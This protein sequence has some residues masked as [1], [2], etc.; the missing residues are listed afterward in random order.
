MGRVAQAFRKSTQFL[1]AR[2]KRPE[3]D[4][5]TPARI[6]AYRPG[7]EFLEDRTMLSV[8]SAHLDTVLAPRT[9]ALGDTTAIAVVNSVPLSSFAEFAHDHPAPS[10]VV[11]VDAG[12]AN[13]AELINGI[14]SSGLVSASSGSAMP[15]PQELSLPANL[16]STNPVLQVSFHGDTEVVVLDSGYDGIQQISAILQPYHGLSAEQVLSHG[17][18]GALQL[19]NTILDARTL[20]Q[21]QA[22]ISA[23]GTALQSGGDIFLYGCDVAQGAGGVQFVQS[24]AHATGA[25]VAANTKATG[26]TAAGGDWNLDY[27]TGPIE[28][29]PVFTAAADA[30]Y[31]GLLGFGTDLKT[32]IQDLLASES[33]TFSQTETISNVS[34]GGFLQLN[35]LTLTENA[36]LSTEGVWSGT[37]GLSATSATLFP[38]SSFSASITSTVD[39]QPALT[40]TFTIGSTSGPDFS[41]SV[42]S[43]ANLVINVGEALTI[44]ASNVSFNY[45]SSPSASDTQTLATIQTAT[46][47]SSQFTS[48]PS[49][50]LHN[51]AVRQDGFSFDSFNLSSPTGSSPSIGNFLTTTG[52]T[53]DVSDFNVSFGTAESHPSLTGTVGITVTGLQLFPT[54]NYVQLQTSGVTA[55]YSFGNFNGTD[56]TGQLSVTISGFGLTM[57][58]ALQLSAVDS[59]GNPADVTITP[60][61]P[62]MATVGS[63]TLSSPEFTGLGTLAVNNLQITQTGFSL[64]NAEWSSGSS[65]TVGNG[66]LAFSGPSTTDSDTSD[67]TTTS[68]ALQHPAIPSTVAVSTPAGTLVLNTDYTLGTD[69]NGNTTVNFISGHI[70]ASGVEVTIAYEEPAVTVDLNNFA[71]EDGAATA[72]STLTGDAVDT[73]DIVSGGAGYTMAPTVTFSGGGGTGAAGTAVLTN[74][75]VTGV[76]ITNGGSG[77]TSAPTV[78]VSSTFSVSGSISFAADGGVL[79]PNVSLLDISVGSLTG[80]FDFGN[81]TAPGLM[82]VQIADLAISLGDALTINLGNVDLTPGQS[83]MLS[84]S[85]VSVT[86][87]L[88]SALPLFT[89]STFDVTQTG[90]SLSGNFTTTNQVAIGN[91]I[92]MAG[93]SIDV[94]NFTV[95]TQATPKISGSITITPGILTLFPGDSAVTSTITGLTGSYDFASASDPGQLSL[96]A[97]YVSLSLFGELSLVAHE[98]TFTPGQSTLAT[99]GSASLSFAPLNNLDVTVQNLAITKTGFTIGFA[100]AT[101]GDIVLGSILTLQAP[102]VTL[103]DLA[104]TD[105]GTLTG[106]VGFSTGVTLQLGTALDAHV[107]SANGTYDLDTGELSL[108]LNTFS[109]TVA[110]FAEVSAATIALSYTPQAST[111]ESNTADGTNA[112][113]SLQHP[114]ISGTV[115][116][117]S[118]V[119]SDGTTN[120]PDAVAAAGSAEITPAVMEPYIVVG[121]ALE[122]D[123]GVSGQQEIVTVTAVTA[124]TFTAT[125]A[126]THSAKF[127][128]ADAVT[129]SPDAVA[130]AG[131]AEITPAVM[132]PYI[133]VGAALEIDEGVSGQQEIVTVTAVTATTF[134]A[135]FANTHGA[136]FTIGAA[137]TLVEGTDYTLG[138]ANGNTTITFTAGHVPAAGTTI[139]TTYRYNPPAEMLLGA[140]GVE[141]FMGTGTGADRVGVD[142]TNGTVALAFFD[143][144]GTI[145]YALDVTGTVNILGLPANTISVIPGA[146]EFQDNTAGALSTTVTVVATAAN[147]ESATPDFSTTTSISLQYAVNPETLVVTATPSVGGIAVPLTEGTDYTLGTDAN[148]NTT[149]NFILDSQG[150]FAG[151]GIPA[152]GTTINSSY[153]YDVGNA[154]TIPLDFTGNET[155]AVAQGL[156]ISV[157]TLASLTGDFSFSQFSVP[158]GDTYVAIGASNVTASVSAGGVSVTVTGA[159][160]GLLIDTSAPSNYAVVADGGADSLTGVPGLTLAGSGLTVQ[161]L[162]G[163]VPSTSLTDVPSGVFTSAV[164]SDF[165]T[166]LAGTSPITEVE[167]TVTLA[168]ANFVSI[169]GSFAFEKFSDGGST[170]LA[171]GASDLN[172]VLGNS[173]TYLSLTDFNLGLVI[174]PG[175]GGSAT[176]YALEATGGSLSLVNVPG[177]GLTASNILVVVRSGLDVSTILSD[178]P[179][180]I[181]DDFTSEIEGATSNLTDIEADAT[182]TVGPSATPV[183]S[184]SGDFGFQSYTDQSGAHQIA[185]G[186]T[187]LTAVIGD[188]TT[189]LTISAATIGVV[190]APST[191]AFALE[192]TGGSASLNGMPTVNGQPDGQPDLTL[193]ANN[194]IVEARE[195]LD[196]SAAK[197][198]PVIQ[199]SG[200]PIALDFSALGAGTGNS[201]SVQGMATLTV[202]DFVSVSGVF[203]LQVN[204]TA[205]DTYLAAGWQGNVTL[206][207]GSASLTLNNLTIGVLVD[208]NNAGTTYA[209]QATEG[210]GSTTTFTGVTGL[211]LSASNLAVLVDNGLSLSTYPSGAPTS[212]TL[213]VSNTETDTPVTSITLQHAA[214]AGTVVVTSTPSGGGR[215][216]TLV[217]GTDYK[218]SSDAN[219]NTVI[220]FIKVPAASST[221]TATYTYNQPAVTANAT[222]TLTLTDN[223]ATVQHAATTGT[224]VVTSTP[225]G[226][227]RAATLVEGTDYKLSSDANGNT[228]ITFIK[229][230]AAGSTIKAVYSYVSQAA[231]TQNGTETDTPVTSVTLQYGVIASTLVVSNGT[232]TLAPVTDYTVGTNASGKTVITFVNVPAPGSTITSSY[233]YEPKAVTENA[234]E[235][236]NTPAAPTT[237]QHAAISGTVV[238][239]SSVPNDGT[240]TSPDGLPAAGSAVVT[241]VVME[242]YIVVGAALEIDE[243]VSGQQEIVTVTAVTATTFTATFAQ[244]HGANFTIADAVTNSPDGVTAAGSAEITPSAMEPYIVVGAALEIDEG[245]SG[246]QEIVTVTA[247]TATTFTATFAN[248]HS[249]NFTIGAAVTLVA[250]VDYTLSTATNGNTIITFINVPAAGSTITASYSYA[251]QPATIINLNFGALPSGSTDFAEIQG[252][253]SLTV[254][255]LATVSGDFGIERYTPSSGHP[256][257]IIGATNINAVL[258]TMDTNVTVTGASFGLMVQDGKYALLTNGGTIKLNGVPDLTLTATSL[259]VEADNGLTFPPGAPTSITTPGGS[260]DLTSLIALGDTTVNEIQV[261]GA[262]AVTNGTSPFVSLSGSFS[263]SESTSPDADSKGTTTTILVGASGVT[264]FIGADGYGVQIN[265]G[266]LGLVIY[267]DSE[268]TASTYALE[269]SAPSIAVVGLPSGISLAGSATVAINTTGAAVKVTIPGTTTTISFADGTNIKSFGGSLT[270]GIGTSSTTETDTS[271]GITASI[272]LANPAL[273]NT[274][275][276]TSTPTGN[277]TAMTLVEGTDYTLSPDGTT[278]NFIAGH[279]PPSGASISITY[280]YLGGTVN[281]VTPFALS[282]NFSFTEEVDDNISK[283]LIGATGISAPSITADG[284]GS[285]SLTN[286]TLGMVFYTD[287]TT[288][289]SLGYALTASAT[290]AATAGN[291]S[292]SGTLTIL[293]N[294]TTAPAGQNDTVTV[295]ATT[296]PVVFGPDQV[297]TATA[298][299]QTIVIGN[300]TLDIDGGFIVKASSA[301]PTSGTG[302]SSK[303]VTGVSIMVVDPNNQADVLFTISA[304]SAVYTSFSGEVNASTV[305]GLS[306]RQDGQDWESGDVDFMLTNV[307]FSIGSYVSFSAA[308][309]DLQHFVVSGV[310][311]DTFIFTTASV[312]LLNNGQPMVSLTGSPT[313]DYVTGNMNNA[314]NGFKLD[315]N[316]VAFTGFTFLDPTY[317]LGPLTLVTPKVELSNFSFALSGALSATVAIG[318]DSATIGSGSLM[319]TFNNLSGSFN[320]TLG[321]DLSHL[322]NPP[323]VTASGFSISATSLMANVG[324]YLTLTDTGTLTIDPTATATQNLI[325]FGTLSAELKVGALD[326]TGSASNFAIEG[327]GSFFAETDFG[328][329][330]SLGSGSSGASGLGWPSW[331][332]LTGASV[333][334]FWPAFNTNPLVFDIDLS[335][336]IANTFIPGLTFSGTVQNVVMDVNATTSP[337]T[338]ELTSIG[339]LGIT[340]GGSMFGGTLSGTLIG[341]LVRFDSAGNVVD[342]LGNIENIDK[343]GNV[344]DTTTPGVGPFTSIFYAGISGTFNFLD[345]SGFSISIGFSQLGPLDVYIESDV[346]IPIGP[347]TLVLTGFNAGIEF[348]TAFPDIISPGGPVVSDALKLTG[349]AFTAPDSLSATQWQEQLQSQVV[350]QYQSNPGGSFAIPSSFIIEAG[351]TLT[352]ELTTSAGFAL[353]GN[354]MFDSN[355]NFLVIGT[356]TAGGGNVSIGAKI[357]ADLASPTPTILFLVQDPAQPNVDHTPP[358]YSFYG[359]VSF[360]LTQADAFQITIAGEMDLNVLSA[361]Q[362]KIN[363]TLILTF[364]S[365]SF[366]ITLSGNPGNPATITI[367]EIQSTPLGTASGSLTIEHSN[368]TVEIWGGFLLTANLTALNAEGI[369]SSAQVNI[370]LNTTETEQTVMVQDASGDDITL[371]LAPESL[372]LFING[373][374][375]FEIDG[376]TVFE[377]DGA[378]TFNVNPSNLT[379]FVQAQLFV[380]GSLKILT[381]NANGLI[382]VQ[383]PTAE[384]D[385]IPGFAAKMTLTSGG[386]TETVMNTATRALSTVGVPLPSVPT[387]ITF[388]ENWLLVVNTIGQ[389]ITYTIPQPVVTSPPSPGI[390]TV[391]GPDYTNA[392][393][394]LALTSYETV[395]ASVV[396]GGT[397]YQVG[398]VLT[399]V[400]GTYTTATTLT[401]SSAFGGAITG[402]T[403]TNG[404]DYTVQPTNSVLS[405][406]GGHGKNATFDIVR[407]L[408]IPNGPPAGELTNYSDWTP[409]TTEANSPYFIVLGRGSVNILNAYT[410]TGN[411]NILADV[412]ASGVSFTLDANTLEAV[413]LGGKTVFSFAV[414]GGI[415]ISDAGVAAALGINFSSGFSLPSSLG[416]GLSA[417]FELELNTTNNQTTIAGF[418][419]PKQQGEIHA[420]GDLTLLGSLVDLQGTFDLTVNSTSVSV[421]VTADVT[422]LGATFTAD[423]FAAIYYGS[424]PGLA[425]DIGLGLPGGAQGIAPI[426]AL[427]DNFV[428]SG[429]FDLELNTCSVARTDPTTGASITP[430]FQVSVSNVGVYLYGFDLTGSV[431]IFITSTGYISQTIQLPFGLGTQTFSIYT[432]IGFGFAANLNLNLFGLASIGISGYFYPDGSFSFTGKAGFQLGDHT[433]GIGGSVS[434]TVANTGFSFSVSGWAA[435][436]GLQI[437]ASGGIAITGSSVDITVAFTVT[438]FPAVDWGLLGS[439]PAVTATS[440]AHFHLGTTSPAPSVAPNHPPPPPP[441]PP[442][443]AAIV[444]GNMLELYVGQDAGNRV[445]GGGHVTAAQNENYS[446]TRVAGDTGSTNGETIQVYALN[447]TQTFYNVQGILVNDTQTWNDTLAIDSGIAVPVNMTLGSGNNTISAGSGPATITIDGAGANQ[448][449]TGAHSNITVAAG[450]SGDNQIGAGAHSTVTI[451]ASGSGN[452]QVTTG[453]GA[454]VSVSGNENNG[455]TVNNSGTDAASV[456]ISGTGANSVNVTNGTDTID[457]ESAASGNNSITAQGQGSSTITLD[458]NGANQITT[459]GSSG[460]PVTNVYLYGSGNNQVGTGAGF[461]NVYDRGTGGNAVSGGAGGGTLYYGVNAGGTAYASK[462]FSR[463]LTTFGNFAAVVSGYAGYQLSDSSVTITGE[464]Y[465]LGLNGVR[466]VTLTAASTSATNSFTLTGW[467][468]NATLNGAGVTNTFGLTPGSGVSGMTDVLSNSSLQVTGGIAQTITLSDIQAANLVGAS[469]G[470][471]TFNISSWTGNGSLT[472][473]AGTSNTL[474]AMDNVTLFTLSNTLFQRTGY[475]DMKLS[476]IQSATLTGG[477]GNN[478]FTLSGWSGNATLDGTTGNNTFNLT[479]TGSGTGSVTVADTGSTAANTDTLN[480]T[481]SRT[482]FVTSTSVTVG[483][484]HVNYGSSGID[485][486]NVIGGTGSLTF[487]V[488]STGSSV[489]TTTVQT[490]GNSNVINVGSKAGVLPSS[491]GV[492][493][494]IAGPLSLLGGGQDTANVDDSGDNLGL[495]GT[496]TSVHLT[497]LGLATQGIAYSGLAALNIKLGS[498][499]NTFN[500]QGTASGTGTTLN[501]GTG[502]DTV[503]VTGT[504]GPLTVN[505]QTGTNTVNVSSNAPTNT[506]TLSVIGGVLTINGATGST[507]ANVSDTGD[508]TTSTSTLSGTG[509]TSTAFGTGG[510]L[511]YAALAVLKVSMGSGGNTFTVASTASGTTTTLNSGTGSDIVNVTATSGP[512]TVN[513]QAGTDTVNVSSNAPTNTGKLSG[514]GAVLTI[515]GGTGSTTANVSDT[516]DGTASTSTLSGTGLTSTAFG[517]GGSLSYAALAALNVAMG[518]GG[519]TFLISNTA[520]GTTTTLNSGTGS[521]TVNVTTT[522][523]PL[524]VNTQAG[525]DTVNVSSNAPTNTGKLSG[526]GAVLTINGGTG[527]TTANVSDTGDGTASNSTLTATALTSTAFGTGGSLSYSSLAALNIS[528]GSGGNT[529]LISNTAIGTTTAVNSGTGADT[530]NVRATGGPTILNTG[531]GSNAN[532]VNVGSTAPAAGGILDF[533]QGALTVVGN[534]ADSMK[535]DDT[536]NT[537]GQIG[538]LTNT[539][540]TG[541]GMGA[542]GITYSGL[543]NLNINLGSGLDTFNVQSTSAITV[544]T[545]HTGSDAYADIVNVGNS[546]DMVDGV[547]GHLIVQGSGLD[548]LN[549]N[550][551]G[552]SAVKTGLLTNTDLTGLA[553]GLLGITYN[554]VDV[555]NIQLGTTPSGGNT[556]NIESTGARTTN[557]Y[558]GDGNDT[559]RVNYDQSGQQTFQ[560]G[561]GKTQTDSFT[562]PAGSLTQTFTLAQAPT[563]SRFVFASVNGQ[564]INNI[565]VN[566]NQVTVTLDQVLLQPMQVLITYL[567]NILNLFGGNGND[568]FDVGLTEQGSALIN[569]DAKQNGSQNNTLIINGSNGDDNFLL[570]R[571]LVATV[572]S[573]Q[574]TPQVQRVNYDTNIAGLTVNGLGGNNTFT[575]D[576]NSAITTING[577]QGQDTFQVGQLFQT[578]RDLADANVPAIDAFATTL[579]TRGYLSNGISYDTSLF[580]G[581]GT[582]NFTVFRNTAALHMF[583]GSGD[584]TFTVRAFAQEGSAGSTIVGGSGNNLIQYVLNAQVDVTGGTGTNTLVIIGTEFN[585]Q[586]VITKDGVFGGGV[587]VNYTNIQQLV[588]DAG[589]GDDTFYVLSTDPSVHTVLDGGLGNNNF[590]IGGDVPEIDGLDNNN[591]PIVLF[592]ATVGPHSM[593]GI[594]NLTIDGEGGN[595]TEGGLNTPVMLP[596]E[597]N[598]LPSTGNVLTYTGAGLSDAVD[599]M[600]IDGSTLAAVGVTNPLV[601]HITDPL[602]QLVGLTLEISSG[603]GVGR[604]WLITAVTQIG[605]SSNYLLTLLN[606]AQPAPEWGLPNSA[607]TYTITHL[608]QSFFVDERQTINTAT[609]YDDQA[610]TN[611]TGNLTSSTITGLGMSTGITYQNLVT[612]SLYA[613]PALDNLTILLGTGVDTF[614]VQGTVANS[615]TK[616]NGHLSSKEY[617]NVF[618]D[619]SGYG[620]AVS[621]AASNVQNVL[622]DLKLVGGSGAGNRLIASDFGDPAS[623]AKVFFTNNSITGFAPAAILYSLAGGFTDGTSGDGIL[624]YGSHQGGNTFNVLSTLAGSTTTIDSAAGNP[625]TFNVGSLTPVLAGGIVD[626]I[627]G[628]LTVEGTGADTMNVDDTGSTSAKTGNLTESMLTGLNMAGITYSGL[629]NLNISLGSGGNT[630]NTGNMFNINVDAGTNLPAVTNIIGGSA[631]K[632]TLVAKWATDF[633]GVLNL[634]RF[635]TSTVTVGNNFNGVMTDTN[636][637]YMPSI[638]IGGSLTALGVLHVFSTSDPANPTTP[639]GLIGDIGTMTVGG[640]IAGLVQVSGN[641]TTLNVGPANTPTVNDVNDGSGKVL[642]GGALTTASV[643]G[644]VSGTIKETLTINSLYIGGSLT[645]TGLISAVNTV[646]PVLGNI[647][648][649]TIGKNLAGTVLVSGTLGTATIGGS[650]TYTGV[651]T[652]GNLNSMTIQGDLAGQLTVLQTLKMLTVHGG[653]PG[654]IVAGQIGTIG[655]YAGYG[656]VVAQIKE[657]GIQRRIEAAVPLAPF[658]TPLPPPNPTPTVSPTGITFQYFYEGLYSPTVEGVN[659][660]TNLANPQLAA[661]VTNATGNTSPDQFDFS[662][663]TYNDAA[664]FNLARLDATG[665]SGI[666]GIRNVAVEGDI[667]TTVTAAASTFFAPDS[668][669]AG[670]YLPKDQ[671]AGVEVRDFVPAASVNAKTIQAVA[672][673]SAAANNGV[674]VTG[675]ASTASAAQY[676]LTRSTLI[677][678]AG[679]LNVN[680]GETFRIPFA[681]LVTQ[682]VSFFIDTSPVNG[683]FDNQDIDFLVQ[684]VST[685]NSNGTGNN[686]SP[687]NVARGAVVALVTAVQTYNAQ[688]NL[689]GSVMESVAM[690]GD[691][692]SLAT[693]QPIGSTSNLP[694]QPFTPSITSTG[695][696]GDLNILGDL[697][698]VTA[699]S[700]FGSLVPSGNIPATSIIQT[701]G[702]RIDPITGASSQVPA[703]LGRVYVATT[704]KGPVVTTSII[705]ADSI[706]G[707]I[708]SRGDIISEI[709][710]FGN[711]AGV[712]ATQGNIGTFFPLSTGTNMRLGGVSFDGM[713]SNGRLVALGN[714]IGDV[715]IFGGLVGGRIASQGSILGNLT[716]D[717]S[718]DA[719]SAI[720]SGGSIGSTL[721]G[722]TLNSGVINGIVA[723]VGSISV[724]KIGSTN[725]ALY[726]K[727]N[728]T[729]DAAVIDAIFSQGVTPL[730]AADPFDQTTPGDLLNL[731]QILVN[732][733]ALKVKNGH[734]SLS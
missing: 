565:Q 417:S 15:Q 187:H 325:S 305:P 37:V 534:G 236:I 682:Q 573:A 289:T 391:M 48:M 463:L 10:Q 672:F 354:A 482:T 339:A 649:L 250:G 164:N 569:V 725:N 167:G 555:M 706:S 243:G 297:G 383:L 199:T 285:F 55:S 200:G 225:S 131:S 551:T 227:G 358:T 252:S 224:L 232:T 462:G 231:G 626:N 578:A 158:G 238:V 13:Y 171:V 42:P 266:S 265:N 66:A 608:A 116:V 103:T 570:R 519:N 70:P 202:A 375:N 45:D 690:R 126:N 509:L 733:S 389:D 142:L 23:W 726:Y 643:S 674:I 449:A 636:P 612:G 332:P 634:L 495:A 727:A 321:F 563:D 705:Q 624:V 17:A 499:T 178:L 414:A 159:S 173:T 121:A 54:G 677:V 281:G 566:G 378:L 603:P 728:D 605:T 35:N 434:I 85:N 409:P 136:N 334:L 74:G 18:P 316:S 475:G 161:V 517:T 402:V 554:G 44:T 344:T 287:T 600:T 433:F 267:R 235:T 454:T 574:G 483:T 411:L 282:G 237:L 493:S 82:N 307:T 140:T 469:T 113:I 299:Y 698:S 273:E 571:N 14:G 681:D 313:F 484:Q 329:S 665:N 95:D 458:G 94:T 322:T 579:T 616:I 278:I 523:S 650:L 494:T 443:L 336:S 1:Q 330:L 723:A 172:F 115:E 485:V 522:S 550:D 222:E 119:P 421:A 498:G 722:T 478:T 695:P 75:I 599:T 185:I 205:T 234:T 124:T 719:N 527:S 233:V 318:A 101:V 22:Q 65:V 610:T 64:G 423:G 129:N 664:K 348:N 122:I 437:S 652:V 582:A 688:G 73:V 215:A 372:N 530:I 32:Y 558:A 653:T 43:T 30:S 36:S 77:Y 429:A 492:V 245:V 568:Q 349:P 544:T 120:S 724:G 520:G 702:V 524:T 310:T 685:A 428:I 326:I 177:L 487:N 8:N 645:Q 717:G 152:A 230:P 12:V 186:A 516:G 253:V 244:T 720:V 473:P 188:S 531:G 168:I 162:Q 506:G 191:G 295:G 93:L 511:S 709:E 490:S 366:N 147:A 309:I 460:G 268:A 716:I 596:G 320:L 102:A 365:D 504:S 403:V 180:S 6:R 381:F 327:D 357:Y 377:L 507:T 338:V 39:G 392:S 259:Q 613:G 489:G 615:V 620:P 537:T 546:A 156:S 214:N 632:D 683:A 364:T 390:P 518:S 92:T 353:T 619:A 38:G 420:A 143:D 455:V 398:D 384:D 271:D 346:P 279:I 359:F 666:S 451:S 598:T 311:T 356:L 262:I 692:G 415:Q 256:V 33:G 148:G 302:Y 240:T 646:N 581:A 496:L 387:G 663:V 474:V 380:G 270:L 248:T 577:G 700:I 497:G 691:G 584:A 622:G 549:V 553:M 68:L 618:S 604:F 432:G 467:S 264:A 201:F 453:T 78:T 210:T 405:V 304:A 341:G 221:I 539:L 614:N 50:T 319:A 275:V 343:D 132:E 701:T 471:N 660:S 505:T 80:S 207:A 249:A 352:D 732:L 667:L 488:Q 376:Q 189:N 133:V 662:M 134:T 461:A 51:F 696:L 176:T 337:P 601:N 623:D 58:Q 521:D 197:G 165:S 151:A 141:A 183:A 79:F 647:N 60:D 713:V 153:T 99:I 56:P 436:F 216:A 638:T 715:S 676:V 625:N 154:T 602:H 212:V 607:S 659:P 627:K 206:T 62:V 730:S 181:Q 163:T 591:N 125:F 28:A 254:T 657:S 633:N 61:Q 395:T 355:G 314:D 57:G 27:R 470:A 137:V 393:N 687:S 394:P 397:G 301:T 572:A 261:T 400:G 25:D 169:T 547:Q 286:G 170:Y 679:S 552:S 538:F 468:G 277:S 293:R 269:A 583:G 46:V 678:P 456:T 697:P 24:L 594:D 288:K 399:V 208:H 533:I 255:G 382:F 83:T 413:T 342:G 606:P 192:E 589:E 109:L 105:G 465:G 4:M 668:S 123:E 510:S 300:A 670:V 223:S 609:I 541:L 283:L 704:K 204:T 340:V 257:L 110:G 480:V 290:A 3:S 464:T 587:D 218:L 76:T 19:G 90:F 545:L 298:A 628:P 630:G 292:A 693:Y 179:T 47:T 431:D 424:S 350:N 580:G 503:N 174:D 640:S 576:D 229:V 228:V 543:A 710:S 184:L 694:K 98:V 9:D 671:L 150:N 146:V 561:V 280:S 196:E 347:T 182:I 96:K 89:L 708:I 408:V 450:G 155:E 107:G 145:T 84:A 703:G 590:V 149:V 396:A 684:G 452:N 362:V 388:G 476:G 528:M 635:A 209:L 712:V 707:Q 11:I 592:P 59:G 157:G 435:A 447:Q 274:V 317:T 315:P 680:A 53:L 41:L 114:A 2:S 686:V 128:I 656:P 500:I 211:S 276:V 648:T 586:F 514:I 360:A 69:A 642:V 639:I 588:V 644:N 193:S 324:P 242:P 263:F 306:T 369:Y 303:I 104:Y 67:G 536:G 217:E 641:L 130:A 562:M 361:L 226:G 246:Q 721:Y 195:G 190:I 138:T 564:A 422:L 472:G 477:T 16:S 239:V 144:A 611:L 556:F 52:V 654:T 331:L 479:V 445:D 106:T 540:L 481:A 491:A 525:T 29:Q 135:T 26:G 87:N 448:I 175:S 513:T 81:A 734:L 595:G 220:T 508:G 373:V 72:T 333:A 296:I 49:P 567:V 323:S 557:V 367:P 457:V 260:V 711:F 729:Q 444:S 111:T 406:T 291:S 699:P 731:T 501:S 247:V 529:F 160:L 371:G 459:G 108:T 631:V 194:L 284:A 535:V 542:D 718:I 345:M 40:G 335:A 386:S 258:G 560:N 97:D 88:F 63:L 385:D 34:L 575:L 86:A 651:V 502:N 21:D 637:G 440:Y 118:S 426:S 7:I 368:G 198:L 617:F 410:L 418:T 416:F 308:S 71:L 425:L 351:V 675:A 512:L 272:S 427:G 441:T 20:Q 31:G 559:L 412:S 689:K 446:L 404:G 251:V 673:G 374:A 112:T 430:G 629:A 363:A 166:L 5:K 91:F 328:V 241:P 439:S 661:R 714:I 401:V 213:P 370:E 127:T 621:S 442:P 655:A 139:S 532:T 100:S 658:P 486:V 419:L 294:T 593:A 597:T 548:I 438:L 407:T 669:P 203:G 219:G 117:V 526:I 515:N 466:S 585:D 379:I 312:A